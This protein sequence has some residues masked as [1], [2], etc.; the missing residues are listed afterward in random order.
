MEV[1]IIPASSDFSHPA[2]RRRPI[3]FFNKSGIDYEIAQ[4]AKYYKYVYVTIAADL[5]LWSAYKKQWNL[6]MPKPCVIFDFCDDLLAASFVQDHLR[7]AYY[8]ISG[9]NKRFNLSYKRTIL[10]MISCA[11]VVVCGSA[12]QK[13]KLDRIHPNVVVVRDFF[14]ADIRNKKM[15]YSLRS[16][17][18]LNIFWEGLSHGNIAMF[19]QLREIVDSINGYEVH[20]HIAT[21]PVYCRIGGRLLCNSTFEVLR[22]IFKGSAAKFHLYDW[23]SET[24]SAIAT[25]CDFA[26][27]PVPNNS[28]MR[29]K[30]E[31]KMLLLWQLGLPVV[32]SDTKSYSRV[33][34][35]AELD[36]VAATLLDWKELILRLASSVENRRE[37]MNRA[38]SYLERFCSEEVILSSWREI[39]K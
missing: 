4:Y 33:M 8:Y 23:S 10:E 14:G 34:E 37:Y 28:T 30:P 17:N 13:L 12:E 18:K 21:D 26:V 11:D 35:K 2:D 3:Y 1:G 9:K 7:A 31:N 38:Q 6:S 36:Y 22:D 20:L 27:I 19:R 39:F 24:F 5:S 15:D 29:M 25:S 16:E 32:A